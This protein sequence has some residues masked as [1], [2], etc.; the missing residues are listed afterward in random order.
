MRAR[1]IRAFVAAA[2]LAPAALLGGGAA[3]A[4]TAPPPAAL[5]DCRTVDIPVSLVPGGPASYHVSA[6]YCLPWGQHPD[7]I[8]ADVSGATYDRG[9]Y[10]PSSVDPNTSLHP[11]T[12]SFVD[13]ELAARQAV[14]D[15]DRIGTGDSSLP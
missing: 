7:V 3:A 10:D 11:G 15:I 9:F 2:L 1:Y 13:K 8:D 12:Y 6:E 4:S 14:L 5:R